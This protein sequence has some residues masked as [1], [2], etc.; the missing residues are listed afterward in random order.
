M[1][2]FHTVHCECDE[3]NRSV[4]SLTNYNKVLIRLGAGGVYFQWSAPYW[5]LQGENT[6]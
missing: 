4:Q 6:R 2:Q 1:T 5:P 3:T